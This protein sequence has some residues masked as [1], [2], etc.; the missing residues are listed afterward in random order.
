M[1]S[2]A[3]SHPFHSQ[4]RS[5]SNYDDPIVLS[6]TKQKLDEQ[7]SESIQLNKGGGV[8]IYGIINILKLN[9]SQIRYKI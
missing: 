3:G 1:Q 4:A 6:Q 8:N 5:I 2:E 7:L 9:L